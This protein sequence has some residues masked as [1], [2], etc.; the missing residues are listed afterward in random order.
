MRVRELASKVLGAAFGHTC[1]ASFA[2]FDPRSSSWRTSQLSLFEASGSCSVDYPKAGMMRSGSLSVLPMLERHTD[3]SVFSSS[4]GVLISETPEER[5]WA[6][7]CS[8]DSQGG[9]GWTPSKGGR[10]LKR[11]IADWPT[12]AASDSKRGAKGDKPF[13]QGGPSLAGAVAALEEWPTP[14]ASRYGSSNNGEREPGQEFRM[15]GKPSLDTIASKGLWPTATSQDAASSRRHGYMPTAHTGTTLTD[16]MC[17]HHGQEIKKAGEPSRMRM[18]LN[19]EFVESLVGLPVGYTALHDS[20]PSATS[21]C[22]TSPK[23]SDSS[24]AG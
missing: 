18:V 2:K 9:S 10:S 12:P 16:A 21:S 13:R 14:T 22:P 7:P 4:P 24:C 11:E 6:T 20:K 1:S 17:S 23:S 5:S 19:P 8:S 3:A 15:Q